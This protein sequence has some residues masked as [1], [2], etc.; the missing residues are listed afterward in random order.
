MIKTITNMEAEA[1]SLALKDVTDLDDKLPT[2]V[3]FRIIQNFKAFSYYADTYR[4]ERDRLI[5]TY[6]NGGDT[7]NKGDEGFDECISEIEK[8]SM[9][10]VEVDVQEI[11]AELLSGLSIPMKCMSALMFI[12]KD[13][14]EIQNENSEI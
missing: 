8:L 2:E 3:G 13:D 14:G 12:T 4:K 10:T 9:M 6:S 11:D 1:V 5:R 7:I